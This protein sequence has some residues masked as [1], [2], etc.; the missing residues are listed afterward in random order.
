MRVEANTGRG[1]VGTI[2]LL[3]RSQKRLPVRHVLMTGVLTRRR[4][5]SAMVFA[6]SLRQQWSPQFNTFELNVLPVLRCSGTRWQ[7]EICFPN[8]S[9]RLETFRNHGTVQRDVFHSKRFS[10]NT[11]RRDQ[12]RFMFLTLRIVPIGILRCD[13]FGSRSWSIKPSEIQRSRA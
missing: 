8:W 5:F 11:R 4:C 9:F 6:R 3:R 2:S 13:L 10:A 1:C 7:I 12:Q